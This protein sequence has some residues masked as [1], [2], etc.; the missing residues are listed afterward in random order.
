[1]V[2]AYE[3]NENRTE[4]SNPSPSATQSGTQRN[5]AA[6][7]R[8]PPEIAAIPQLWGLRKRPSFLLFPDADEEERVAAQHHD[9][10]WQFRDIDGWHQRRLRRPEVGQLRLGQRFEHGTIPR[11]AGVHRYVIGYLVTPVALIWGSDKM[12]TPTKTANCPGD[13]VLDRIRFCNRF[14]RR[15]RFVGW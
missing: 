11:P 12:D 14:S 13:F 1:M 3:P 10:P 6:F 15:G 2:E 8:K 5:S 9:Q 7:L 4:S